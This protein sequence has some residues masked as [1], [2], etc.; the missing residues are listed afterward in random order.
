MHLKGFLNFHE[1][2]GQYTHWRAGAFQSPSPPGAQ[3]SHCTSALTMLMHL[4]FFP[5]VA[6]NCV[7]GTRSLVLCWMYCPAD[8][9][10]TRSLA[11][12]SIK[13]L[14]FEVPE[15]D[16]SYLCIASHLF[17]LAQLFR[18]QLHKTTHLMRQQNVTAIKLEPL[19]SVV[20]I[21]AINETRNW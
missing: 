14:I 2:H 16:W 1:A 7:P 21:L 17:Q 12:K 18:L 3:R 20:F 9:I 10:Q 13:M 8:C 5:K 6:G 4:C 11:W 15:S 19:I